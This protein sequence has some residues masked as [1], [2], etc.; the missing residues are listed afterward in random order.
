[1]STAYALGTTFDTIPRDVPYVHFDPALHQ[2]WARTIAPYKRDLNFGIAWSGSPT[3]VRNRERSTT[4]QALAPLADLKGVRFF[5]LQFGDAAKMPA[6]PGLDLVDFTGDIRNFDDTA[7]LIAN[8]DLV[9]TVDTSVCHLAGAMGKPTFAMLAYSADWRWHL[10][11]EDSPWYPTM[12][13]F[14]QRMRRDWAEVIQ[15]VRTAMV[16]RLQQR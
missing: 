9:V 5:S 10:D 12:R 16:E 7:A 8:L 3:Q 15:R 4:L 2:Q 6:P 11:R 13:L 1:M 14:R